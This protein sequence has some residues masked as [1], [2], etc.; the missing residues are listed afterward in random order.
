MAD[1][2]KLA[3]QLDITFSAAAEA[4]SLRTALIECCDWDD[5]QANG[6]LQDFTETIETLA[7]YGKYNNSFEYK[8]FENLLKINM[9]V[10]VTDEQ[11]A[12]LMKLLR[13]EATEQIKNTNKSE[14]ARKEKN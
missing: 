5:E 14:E 6:I 11:F 3:E 10:K 7:E 13:A 9:K 4:M 1:R 8:D 12:V 2:K